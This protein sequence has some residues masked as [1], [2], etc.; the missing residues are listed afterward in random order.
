LKH[1]LAIVGGGPAGLATAIGAAARGLSSVVIERRPGLVDKAC[2]E[3]LLPSGLGHLEALGVTAHLDPAGFSR[4]EGIR[5]L[6]EDG[7]TAEAR[8]PGAGGLGI[9]RTA[10]SEAMQARARHV[11]VELRAPC[12]LLGHARGPRGVRLETSEGP[13]E[14]SLLVAADG[15]RSPIRRAAGLDG[16]PRALRRLGLRQHFRME[17]WSTF[18]E[19]YFS[20]GLEAYVT[21]AGPGRVGVAFL[22][23]EGSVSGP[24]TIASFTGRFPALRERLE[25]APADSRPRGAG[26]LFQVALGAVGDRLALVGDAAGYIDALTGEG[27][28]VAFAGADA[29]CSR[30]PAALARGA[31]RDALV[32]YEQAWRG[33]YRHYALVA[34]AMLA[35]AG[36]PSLR[37]AVVRLLARSPGLFRAGL[38]WAVG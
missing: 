10:L 35:L 3:G 36:R 20:E 18:V 27:L 13:I 14:A 4:I 34:R 12:T 1:D 32:P 37:R 29:L 5:Y 24:A 23:Q 19:V 7:T 2:G 38:G 15:L 11:G 25:G 28:S 30:L 9:R 16:P 26:P 8:L 17:P 22:W 33:I 6:Q 31:S 21:P